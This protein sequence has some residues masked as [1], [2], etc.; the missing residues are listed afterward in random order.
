MIVGLYRVPGERVGFSSRRYFDWTRRT[1]QSL[2]E[3]ESLEMSTK[4]TPEA[5]PLAEW[6]VQRIR[7][8]N[9]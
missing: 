7:R 6:L 4:G 9:R 5:G 8:A 2:G 1:F 3:E